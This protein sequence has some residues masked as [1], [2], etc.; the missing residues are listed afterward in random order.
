MNLVEVLIFSHLRHIL[1]FHLK[2]KFSVSMMIFFRFWAW[3]FVITGISLTA[4]VVGA[5]PNI[6]FIMADDLGIGDLSSHGASDMK[7]PNI[8]RLMASGCRFNNAYANCPVCSPTRAA[9]LTG[10][11]PDMV[12]VPGVIRTHRVNN[13]GYLDPEATT[14]PQ[15]LKKGGYHSALIGKW[16]LGLVEPNTPIGRGFDYFKGFLGDMMDDYYHHRRHGVNYMREGRK[17]ITPKGHATDLFS[18]W[19]VEY[20]KSRVGQESPFF[21]FLSYNAPHTPIQPPKEWTVRVKEREKGIS[22]Q[23]ARLVALIEHMDE[24]IGRVIDGLRKS[25]QYDNTLIIFTSDNGGQGNV[26]AR[27]APWKGEKQQMWEGGLRVPTCA[28]W[29]GKIKPGSLFDGDAMTMDWLPTL[30][31]VAGVPAPEGIEGKSLWGALSGK[32]VELGERLLIWVRREGGAKYGGQD[33]YAVRRGKWKLL[34]N[35]AFEPFSL[36]DLK[37]D[38]GEQQPV[39]KAGKE[40]RELEFHLREHVRRAG[41]I[42]W[43]GREPDVEMVK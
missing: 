13:W 28:S 8:D 16:H 31:E 15:I 3:I 36:F 23:R 26:G 43:Q 21:L 39:Q 19:A 10:R 37:A 1:R 17:V 20:I 11:Y 5:P 42:R 35:S 7:T 22:E 25:G 14:L 24:G 34:Q 29:T 38:P 9:F 2:H 4:P 40:R 32:G 6:L 18:D 33:Y 30:A 27:N 12:G 41:F